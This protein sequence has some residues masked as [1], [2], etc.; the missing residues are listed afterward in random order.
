MD[1]RTFLGTMAGG[2]LAAPPATEGQ[3]GTKVPR[4]A[5]LA[6][7]KCPTPDSAFGTALSELG[8]TWGQTIHVLCRSAEEDYGRLWDAAAALAA[9]N[10]DVIVTFSHI[11]TYAARRATQSTP[12]VMIASGD[13]V[14]SGL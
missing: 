4:V 11:T 3:H 9:Q 2:L 10:V 8:Y 13:P 6:W 12:I 5:L 14:R 1:R 7:E